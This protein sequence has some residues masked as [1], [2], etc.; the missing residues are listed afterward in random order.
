MLRVPSLR[1]VY[2]GPDGRIYRNADA[3]PRAF[4]AGR[5]VVVHGRDA[6]LPP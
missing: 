2:D 3:L 1:L 6:A 4:V 5:Q